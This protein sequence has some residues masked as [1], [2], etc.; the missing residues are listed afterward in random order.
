MDISSSHWSSSTPGESQEASTQGEQT[1]ASS[2]T[3][4]IFGE[5]SL[6]PIPEMV[7]FDNSDVSVTSAVKRKMTPSELS[8]MNHIKELLATNLDDATGT[9][10]LYQLQHLIKEAKTKLALFEPGE[11]VDRT[12]KDLDVKLDEVHSN[13]C[14]TIKDDMYDKISKVF[15][16]LRHLKASVILGELVP[17]HRLN[18]I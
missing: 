18:T 6:H 8:L 2:S 15:S 4:G 10:A 5:N 11:L 13:V 14:F 7:S 17:E 9:V 3:M 16:F 1:S 12:A